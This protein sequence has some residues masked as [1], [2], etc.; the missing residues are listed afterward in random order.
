MTVR[1]PGW[2]AL[3]LLTGVATIYLCSQINGVLPPGDWHAMV[4]T[5]LFVVIW[6]ALHTCCGR[7]PGPAFAI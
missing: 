4:L 5:M 7:S 6:P 3:M 2:M 1:W